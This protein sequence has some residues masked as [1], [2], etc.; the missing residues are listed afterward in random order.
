MNDEL[1]TNILLELKVISHIKCGMKIN[2]GQP[3]LAI[4]YPSAIH[5]FLRWFNSENRQKNIDRI[6]KTFAST[7][8]LVDSLLQ[9]TPKE[10]QRNIVLAR[11]LQAI[12][13]AVEGLHRLKT[14]YSLDHHI[15]SCLDVQIENAQIYSNNIIASMGL[16][17]SERLMLE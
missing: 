4:H 15:V 13:G 2:T 5:S 12:H 10:K 8:S 16:T 14:T 3:Q 9:Q 6:T 17:H 7:F 11:L 1:I